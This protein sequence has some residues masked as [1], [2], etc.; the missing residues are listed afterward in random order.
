[1]TNGGLQGPNATTYYE[2][3]EVL[4][5]VTYDQTGGAFRPENR[6]LQPPRV[7][8]GLMTMD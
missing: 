2:D 7:Y 8:R 5:E 1:M 4:I 6:V 3:P